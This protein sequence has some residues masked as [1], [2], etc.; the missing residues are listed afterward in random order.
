[1]KI[2]YMMI[3]WLFLCSSNSWSQNEPGPE[4]PMVGDDAPGFVAESTSGVLNFPA[5]YGSKWKIIF[6]H[7]RDFTPVC[8]SEI[9]ELAH[10]QKDFDKLNVKDEDVIADLPKTS[11]S[12]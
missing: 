3:L 7:P 5:D 12:N 4:I 10:M 9:L 1:M 6:S 11:C 2:K 8:S